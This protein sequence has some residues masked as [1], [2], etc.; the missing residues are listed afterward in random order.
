MAL[1][2]LIISIF[3]LVASA[4]STLYARR[5]WQIERGRDQVGRR[6]Q[7]SAD[8]ED[9]GGDYPCLEITNNG[10]EDR[11]DVVLELREPL[12]GYV[13]ALTSLSAEGSDPGPSVRLGSLASAETKRIRAYR[14]DPNEQYGE[15]VLYG[16]CSA[17]DQ[18]E[19]RISIKVNIPEGQ[20]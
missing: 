17:A 18:T 12:I 19:W 1:A 13:P 8:Y 14:S 2:G 5:I 6:P 11:A 9:Y 15:A 4:G 16:Y 3:A 20:N 10:Q 7:I